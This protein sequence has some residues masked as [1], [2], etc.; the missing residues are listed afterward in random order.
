M[1]DKKENKNNNKVHDIVITNLKNYKYVL[2][3][4]KFGFCCRF[5]S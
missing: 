2:K 3:Y 4:L 1:L 5:L